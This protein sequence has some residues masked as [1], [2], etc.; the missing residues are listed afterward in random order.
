MLKNAFSFINTL[1]KKFPAKRWSIFLV[2]LSYLFFTA[3][4]MGPSVWNC[5]DTLYGF[6]DNTAGPVW[7]Y[8][9]EPKQPP[10]GGFENVTNYPVGENLFSPVSY[11]LSGQSYMI[12]GISRLT[13]PVCGYNLFNML[14]FVASSLVMFGFVY[15]ILRN[16]WLAWLAG[17]A[18]SFV[19]YF[20]VKV[21][22][23]P[24][25]GYQALLIAVIW[26]FFNLL[27][28][29]R[30]RDVVY[31]GALIA[32]CFYFDPYFSLLAA[33]IVAP[34]MLV[35]GAV[36]LWRLWKRSITKDALLKQLKLLAASIAVL[37]AF[38]LPLVAVTLSHGKEIASTVAAYRGNVLFEAR[39]CSNL[40]HEYALPF[41]Y[42]MV[43]RLTDEEEFRR[44]IDRLH[45]GMTCGIG[46]DT[47]GISLA[48]LSIVGVGTIIFLWER[49]NKR[50]L[51]FTTGYDKRLLV[52]GLA[53]VGLFAVILALPPVTIG[54]LPTPSYAMIEITTTWRTLTRLF[55]V[56]N[57]A[58]VALFCIFLAYIAAN[59]SKYKRFLIIGFIA[60]FLFIFAEYQA[61]PPFYGNSLGTFSISKDTPAAYQWLRE[62]KDIKQIA[63][64]PIER[65]GG[66]SNAMAYYLS[67][68]LFHKKVLF[69]GNVANTYEETLRDSLKD[70]S[71]NQTLD[72]LHS[73]G[74]D[75][76]VIH[77][78]KEEEV[79]KIPGLEVVYSAV[80]EAVSIH[81]YTPLVKDDFVVIARIVNRPTVNTMLAFE[82]G[83]VRNHLIIKSAADWEYEALNNSRLKVIGLPGDKSKTSSEP[84]RQCFSVRMAGET[85]FADLAITVDGKKVQ[86]MALGPGYQRINVDAGQSIELSNPKGFNMRVKDLGCGGSER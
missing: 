46:E 67:M 3:Y 78:I 9:L 57:I 81:T 75:A 76:V 11:S 66:E 31:L 32:A 48:V 25:Y 70:I 59:F 79:R 13:N 30:K 55:V 56:V 29:Q 21:G 43:S 38:L 14:G 40:P 20:Q 71:D 47:V 50:K 8:S 82:S 53:A 28:K 83:F 74:I 77:G 15:S 52:I 64:Y 1:I 65:S 5:N 16:R 26:A 10:L 4:Y 27:K 63:E 24:G 61:F 36:S 37:V 22:G 44:L 49:I 62:Q 2:I 54:G 68:Q 86:T 6:G 60:I 73:I 18:V 19:P 33:S 34:L 69:N 17:Y 39:S 84:A 72:V 45:N 23:H 42:H 7:K 85:D 12:W 58:A 35:W 41:A 51:K 80:P